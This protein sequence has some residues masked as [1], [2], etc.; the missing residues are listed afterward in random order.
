MVMLL[1][2]WNGQLVDVV[3]DIVPGLLFSQVF[4]IGS[5]RA[6]NICILA[7]DFV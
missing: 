3:G 6:G 1:V 7:L 4:H 5:L 2:K